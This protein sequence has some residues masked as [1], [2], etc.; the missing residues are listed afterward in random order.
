MTALLTVILVALVFG[1]AVLGAALFLALAGPDG[2]LEQRSEI[3]LHH[4]P[5]DVDAW[6]TDFSRV[7][8]WSS[9]IRSCV[10]LEPVSPFEPGAR[11]QA[12][13]ELGGAR[14]LVVMTVMDHVPGR[15]IRV[16]QQSAV[17]ETETI[18]DLQPSPTGQTLLAVVTR[19][20]LR[21]LLKFFAPSQRE[22]AQL[23][24][25]QDLSELRRQMDDHVALH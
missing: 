7:G 20:R 3:E 18:Y 21:G 17:M 2:Q 1:F 25:D 6:L 19:S 22:V 24:L 16:L 4:S 5:E 8:R 12:E 11:Y 10:P 15:R 14:I 23:R 9:Q 13:V